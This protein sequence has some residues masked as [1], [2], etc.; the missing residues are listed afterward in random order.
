MND[1]GGAIGQIMAVSAPERVRSMAFSNCD[2]HDNWPPVTLNEIREAARTGVF[3]DQ[4]GAFLT[5]PGQF[6]E[7]MGQ[8]VYEDPTFATPDL[9]GANIAP[10][11][12]SQ[13]RKDAFNRYVGFQDNSPLVVIEDDVSKLQTPALIVWGAN[14]PF[15]PIEWAHWLH[16][17]LPKAQPVVELESAMLFFP[18]ERPADFNA[19]LQAFWGNLS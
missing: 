10:L 1:S 15:F 11:V 3:A 19:P 16:A 4:M 7:T 6:A 5:A 18:E 2:V 14:D 17:A 12:S 9:L 8:L 13:E